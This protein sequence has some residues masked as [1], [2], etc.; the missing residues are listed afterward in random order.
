MVAQVNGA[1]SA[2]AKVLN[3]KNMTVGGTIKAG[4]YIQLG[5]GLTSRL[6]K[7]LIDVTADGSDEA[8]LDI[9]PALRNSYNDSDTVVT[10]NPVGL[11]R[12]TANESPYTVT[13]GLLYGGMSFG[14]REAI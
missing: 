7:N 13:P 1:H 8:I 11:F 3:L 10:V 14:A 6:H 2:R 9:W 5:T 4:D 12:L